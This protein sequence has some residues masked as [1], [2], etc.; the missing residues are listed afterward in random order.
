[1]AKARKPQDA[2]EAIERIVQARMDRQGILSRPNPPM[3]WYVIHEGALRHVIG[4]RDVMGLQLDRLVKAAEAP[5][6]V[7]QV[8]PY[9]AHDHAGTEGLLYLYE[10]AGQPVTAYSECFG[11]GRLI[12]DAQ[13]ISD[14]ATVMGMLRAAALPLRDS[15]ALLRQIRRDLD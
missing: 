7:V 9:S 6:I 4:D 8:L 10:R 13:E 2:E 12:N 3:L 14:L 11:G 1:M 5:G 15:V